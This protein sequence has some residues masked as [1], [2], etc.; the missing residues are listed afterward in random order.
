MSISL[1]VS[2]STTECLMKEHWAIPTILLHAYGW[3]EFL[4]NALHCDRNRNLS[5]ESRLTH[6]LSPI[7]ALIPLSRAPHEIADCA[8]DDGDCSGASRYVQRHSRLIPAVRRH[9]ELA[10]R[11]G[12][13]NMLSRSSNAFTLSSPS[14]ERPIAS[15]GV[16]HVWWGRPGWGWHRPWGWRR[17]W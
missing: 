4:A 2:V 15:L 3:D 9:R 14:L 16:E 8:S 11:L 17:T 1:R 6:P 7:Q 12:G 10:G 5:I 13:R